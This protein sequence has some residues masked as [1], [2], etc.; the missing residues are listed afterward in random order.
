MIFFVGDDRLRK[1]Q[2]I[3]GGVMTKLRSIVSLARDKRCPYTAAFLGQL[4]VRRK[5]NGL[6][7][8]VVS[9]RGRTLLLDSARFFVWLVKHQAESKSSHVTNGK[10]VQLLLKERRN[11]PVKKPFFRRLL[12]LFNEILFGKEDSMQLTTPSMQLPLATL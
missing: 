1:E 6:D 11:R 12:D 3:M 7:E 4:V 2:F 10:R 9:K 5:E 8:C